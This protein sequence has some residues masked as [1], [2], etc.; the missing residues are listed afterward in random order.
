MV[1]DGQSSVFVCYV[2]TQ[3]DPDNPGQVLL[4]TENTGRGTSRLVEYKETG[5]RVAVWDDRGTLNGPWGVAVAPATGFVVVSG[6]WELPF[7]NGVKLGDTDAL[8]FAA[9]PNDET[10]GLFGSLRLA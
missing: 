7:G 10:E 6:I 4:A 8:H 2:H 1:I 3:E 5:E 9:G